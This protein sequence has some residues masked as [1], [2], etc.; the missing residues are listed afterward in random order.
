MRANLFSNDIFSVRRYLIA[1]KASASSAKLPLLGNCSCIALIP[2]IPG[3]M[4]TLLTYIR[5]GNCSCI[6]LI[7]SIHG[8]MLTPLT[9]VPV[10]K[11]AL[12][13]EIC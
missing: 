6:A 5:V 7:P 2:S 1:R 3:H 9:Y 4:L 10:G 13:A 12:T 8:H 11:R